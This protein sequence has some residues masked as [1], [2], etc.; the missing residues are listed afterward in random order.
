LTGIFNPFTFNIIIDIIGNQFTFNVIIGI[1]GNPFI[2]NV[3][4]DIVGYISAIVLFVFYILKSFLFLS[5]YFI[6]LYF[7]CGAG[8]QTQG[9]TLAR[10]VLYH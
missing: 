10:K 3:I 1:V 8:E 7:S 4:I 5:A 6:L 2:F 9:L